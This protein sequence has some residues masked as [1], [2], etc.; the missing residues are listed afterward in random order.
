M[1]KKLVFLT[2][3]GISEESGMGVFRGPNGLWEDYDPMEVCS[4]AGWNKNPKLCQKFYNDRR[5]KLGQ[6]EPNEAHFLC[7]KLSDYFNVKIITT[8]VD[9][10]HERAGSKNILHLHGEL[11]K[12]C[13]LDKGNVEDIGYGL[14]SE[15][16][17]NKRPFVVFF[18]EDVPLMDKATEITKDADIIVIVGSSLSVYP[19]NSLISHFKGEKIVY[20]DPKANVN[21][22]SY[23]ES[24]SIED[25]KRLYEVE[26]IED[27]ATT[28]LR[29]MI[30]GL[31]IDI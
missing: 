22:S 10:L 19:A 2:G 15:V 30:R 23:L 24:A 18:G 25:L 9:D 16:D 5:I 3:A 11:T 28:G 26:V 13:D 27:K 12:V 4:V 31:N 1:K 6:I 17:I 7:E 8:N 14:L 20:I 29:K 21:I